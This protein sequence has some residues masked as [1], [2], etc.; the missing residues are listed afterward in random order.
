M[1]LSRKTAAL[2]GAVSFVALLA[3][4]QVAR[5]AVVVFDDFESYQTGSR[6]NFTGFNDLTVHDGNVDLIVNPDLF[7]PYGSYSV[8]LDGTDR[9][10]GGGVLRTGQFSFGAG[11]LVRLDFDISGNQRG[12]PPDDFFYG[13]ETTALTLFKD[14][15]IENAIGAGFVGI[16]NLGPGLAAASGVQSLVS[17]SPWTHYGISFVAGNAG[18][19]SAYLGTSSGDFRGPVADNFRLSI[20]AQPDVGGVPEPATWALMLGGFGLAGGMLRLARGRRGP[21]RVARP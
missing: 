6:L 9:V 14:V 21:V 8:D 13:I 10:N 2:A 20:S 18:T 11:D 7:T 19:L 17:T 1:T 5:A 3:T 4:G 16:G 15:T 12:T